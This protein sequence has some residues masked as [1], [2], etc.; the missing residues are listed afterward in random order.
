MKPRAHTEHENLGPYPTMH[1]EPKDPEG[2]QKKE[3]IKGL[4]DARRCAVK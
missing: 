3:T 1:E 2:P 4:H